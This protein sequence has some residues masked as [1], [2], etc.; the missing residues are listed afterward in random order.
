MR[1]VKHKCLPYEV[2]R[3]VYDKWLLVPVVFI[4]VVLPLGM[5]LIGLVVNYG[6]VIDNYFV[7]ISKATSRILSAL[8]FSVA[9]IPFLIRFWKRKVLNK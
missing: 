1:Q 8:F 5:I 6:H 9:L 7:G 3:E 4:F 2:G